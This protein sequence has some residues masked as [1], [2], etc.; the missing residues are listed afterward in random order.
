MNILYLGYKNEYDADILISLSK[1]HEVNVLSKTESEIETDCEFMIVDD[2]LNPSYYNNVDLV[3]CGESAFSSEEMN[4]VFENCVSG[5]IKKIVVL[6]NS[7]L[8]GKENETLD[9]DRVI[10]GKYSGKYGLK[11]VFVRIPCLYGHRPPEGLIEICKSVLDRNSVSLD[12]GYNY[13]VDLLSINDFCEFFSGFIKNFDE[14]FENDYYILNSSY[15]F[16][17]SRLV[18]TL[19]KRYN[20][21]EITF[22]LQK[23]SISFENKGVS[24]TVNSGNS[25]DDINKLL[26][27]A[28][29]V[30]YKKGLAKKKNIGNGVLKTALFLFFFALIACYTIAAPPTAELQFVDIRFIFLVFSAIILGKNYGYL[31]AGL[32]SLLLIAEKL[33]DGYAW[34]TLFYNVNNWVTIVIYIVSSMVIGMLLYKRENKKQ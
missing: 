21:P 32:C 28:E 15:P 1:E 18:E 13:T 3:I 6:K 24:L 30:V 22:E 11:T 12:C 14:D 10:A 34:Y 4:S 8:L 2:V 27:E 25:F 16:E 5:G 7:S 9:I 29:N 17:V 23:E 33:I 26:D 31:S 19:K 20:D